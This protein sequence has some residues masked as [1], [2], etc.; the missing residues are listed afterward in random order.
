MKS[1]GFG[2]LRCHFQCSKANRPFCWYRDSPKKDFTEIL[3]MWCIW[4]FSGD[5]GMP[6]IHPA[7]GHR[8]DL[9][10]LSKPKGSR[11]ALD[12]LRVR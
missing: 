6:V 1:P 12:F 7:S 9:E 11:E 3:Q 5:M 10:Q 2:P 8:R 4:C